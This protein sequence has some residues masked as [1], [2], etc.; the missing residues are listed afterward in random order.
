MRLPLD[1]KQGSKHKVSDGELI[2]LSYE[3]KTKVKVRFTET[4]TERLATSAQIRAGNVK[5][6][7]LRNV[8]G[9]GFFGVGTHKSKVLGVANPAYQCWRDMLRRCYAPD[10][11]VKNPT[12]A[13][14]TVCDEWHN[15]QKFGDWYQLNYPLVGG[16]Y[17]IDKDTNTFGK[18]GKE[19]SPKRCKF[20]TKEQNIRRSHSICAII[21]S[22]SGD[23]VDVYGVTRFAKENGLDPVSLWSV[24][25]GKYK[26]HKG[27]KLFKLIDGRVSSD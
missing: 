13:G 5:D 18:V 12:Y 6:A 1:M 3:S 4:G 19:Y 7:N 15:F 10:R 14:C 11:D 2:V 27:W 17:E 25:R 8:F 22:P 21:T 24:V 26:Q 9:V 16:K 23:N 20:I